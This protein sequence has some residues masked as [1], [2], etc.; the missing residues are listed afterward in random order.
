MSRCRGHRRARSG[1]APGS[2]KLCEDRGD[3][4]PPIT[5]RSGSMTT[6]GLVLFGLMSVIWGIPYLFIRVDVA[7]ISPAVLVLAR[8]SLAAAILLPI[9]LVRG[10]LRPILARWR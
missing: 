9:A 3:D 4:R 7:E 10:D 2:A 8:T 5:R 6:R 1:A